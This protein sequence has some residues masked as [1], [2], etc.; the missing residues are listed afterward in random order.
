MSAS[1]IQPYLVLGRLRAFLRRRGV[2]GG[3]KRLAF[4]IQDGGSAAFGDRLR[5]ALTGRIPR[6]LPAPLFEPLLWLDERRREARS[7]YAQHAVPVRVVIPSYNDTALL[8]RCL[9]SLRRTAGP[10]RIVIADDASD[11]AH[12]A[13]LETLRQAH[14]GI[15]LV[16][17]DENRGYAGNCNRG[18]ARVPAGH[19]AVLLNSDTE[20]T[21][22]W[23][24]VLQHAAHTRDWAIVAPKLLFPDG[25]IQFAGGARHRRTP[26]WF[27]HRFYKEPMHH[28]PSM[29]PMPSFFATG[30]CLYLRAD[31]LAVLGMLDPDY[32]M[33]FE[34]VDYCIRAWR[35]GLTVGYH[36]GA[37]VRHHESATR[38]KQLGTREKASMAH[39]W[40]K[41]GAFFERDVGRTAGCKARV[42]FVTQDT[43]IGG[44]HRVVFHH[45]STLAAAG[46]AAELW[47]V[48]GS[49]PDW[50]ALDEA[51]PVRR[52]GSHDALIEALRP[53]RAI[54]V[55]TWW[56][57]AD[58]V[59]RASV[60]A[61]IPA[62]HVQ[63]I[64]TS[65]YRE[66]GERAK[67]VLASYRPEFNYSTNCEWISRELEAQFDH[68][69]TRIGLGYDS[70]VFVRPAMP[71]QRRRSV[72]VS[73]RGEPLK[74]FSY[75][76]RIMRELAARGFELQAYGLEPRL[77]EDLPG[78]VFHHRP[79]SRE[80]AR[81]YAEAG[82]Y[83]ST[84]IHEG[85]CLP[86]IEAM[87]CGT[88]TAMTDALGNREY[89]R[90]GRNCVAIP[91]DDARAAADKIA[92]VIDDPRQ[93]QRLIAEGLRTAARYTWRDAERR[94]VEYFTAIAE[95]PVYGMPVGPIGDAGESP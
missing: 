4:I 21:E 28:A 89:M 13:R 94:V 78:C 95:R 57:T 6:S 76:R 39:F 33:A 14:S 61:G 93:C 69:S 3:L 49:R 88:V 68:R 46:F 77:V 63:D 82:V 70:D 73:A 51:V 32:P 37:V 50:Y 85:F 91:F 44:G 29:E 16:L 11:Q 87:A 59:W 20:L 65:Y 9:A 66:D 43:G 34:D 1:S 41:N 10:V 60:V 12:R 47:T 2:I 58:A 36:P 42:I 56:A 74:D 81:L 54:K 7:W 24:A 23:L 18:L 67:S 52:L 48:E 75:A 17:G 62:Y 79:S 22:D 80:L 15:E 25:R 38:G 8:E 40:I 86:P 26:E 83:L 45:L 71:A 53:E 64:E 5:L 19:D 35:N 31:A 55:A 27:E 90:G 84:S 92:A 30:A 72:L